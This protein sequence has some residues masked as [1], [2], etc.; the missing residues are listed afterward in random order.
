MAPTVLTPD[1]LKIIQTG[2]SNA[3]YHY[4]GSAYAYGNIGKAFADAMFKMGQSK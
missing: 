4:M 1:E 3:G 2:Q